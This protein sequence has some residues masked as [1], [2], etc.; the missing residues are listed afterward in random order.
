[1]NSKSAQRRFADLETRM[2]ACR[3]CLEAG[4]FI[5]PPAVTKG[6]LDAKIMT[7]GQAPGVTE[8]KAGR[9]FNATSGTRLFKWFG[10][11]GIDEDWFR[12]TQYMTAVTKCFPGKNKTGSGDRAPS[13][14]EQALCRPYLEEELSLVDPQLIIPIGRLAIEIFYGRAVKLE[15]IIGKQKKDADRWIIPFPHPSGASRWHQLA[16]NRERISKAIRLVA[17]QYKLLFPELATS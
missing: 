9:P 6:R 15:E 4:F 12:R 2:R 13:P 10:E 7:I 8:V 11:A 3:L 14:R 17:K 16:E 1:V 5:E